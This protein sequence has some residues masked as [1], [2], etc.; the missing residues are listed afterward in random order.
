MQENEC[1]FQTLIRINTTFFLKDL[2]HLFLLFMN[3]SPNK[4]ETNNNIFTFS[5]HSSYRLW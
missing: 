2:I 5:H 1:K 4:N 3:F